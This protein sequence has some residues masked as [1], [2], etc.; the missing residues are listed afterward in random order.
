MTVWL[1]LGAYTLGAISCWRSF[2]IG[3]LEA[4][5][6]DFPRS[7]LDNTDRAFAAALGVG[8]ALAWPIALPV[9]IAWRA[10]TRRGL[11]QTPTERAAAERRELEALR[12]MAREHGLPMPGED[13]R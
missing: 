4:L 1:I 9:R 11:L 5:E 6:R 8:L 10:V 3:A 13:G 2:A 12:K 7:G